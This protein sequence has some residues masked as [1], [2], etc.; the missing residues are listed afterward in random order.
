[1][2][3]NLIDYGI[4][5]EGSNLRA[6]VCYV[7]RRIYIYPTKCGLAA[8]DTG[9]YVQR[10]AYTI[11]NGKRVITAMGYAIP[12]HLIDECRQIKVPDNV[13]DMYHADITDS[14][15]HKG[16]QAAHVV[17]CAAENGYLAIPMKC[18]IVDN[19]TMQ[20]DGIDLVVKGEALVQVKCDYKGGHRELGGTGNL[21]LQVAES[22]PLK[23]Y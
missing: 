21:Y 2:E 9:N 3:T 6:H 10:P 23:Q 13:W 20:R 16:L 19:P 14:T 11:V 1:M 17:A 4:Q 12:Y 8:I 22:N 15:S 18:N 7:A 5:V